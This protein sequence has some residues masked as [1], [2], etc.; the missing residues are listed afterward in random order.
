METAAT[1]N[2]AAGEA[3][4]HVSGGPEP[5]TPDRADLAADGM[6]RDAAQAAARA[7]LEAR[8]AARRRKLEMLSD[9]GVA[10]SRAVGAKALRLLGADAEGNLPPAPAAEE[11]IE[12]A[13]AAWEREAAEARAGTNA[14]PAEATDRA[15][16]RYGLVFARISRMAQI[17][18]EAEARFDRVPAAA[19]R[20]EDATPGAGRAANSNRP[21]G[22]PAE[23]L[24]K[25]RQRLRAALEDAIMDDPDLDQVQRAGKVRKLDEAMAK[26]DTDLELLNRPF[27][28]AVVDICKDLGVASASVLSR[29]SDADM[30]FEDELKAAV[31][32][33]WAV[34][35][36]ECDAAGDAWRLPAGI[37]GSPGVPPAA[38]AIAQARAAAQAAMQAAAQT[39]TQAAAEGAAQEGADAAAP[40][41]SPD[42]S[43][44]APAG[45]G[46]HGTQA[47]GPERSRR[48]GL[49]APPSPTARGDPAVRF[50]ISGGSFFSR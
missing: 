12:A 42:P 14:E 26:T 9:Q 50:G 37:I 1:L 28:L 17:L 2:E 11:S 8:Y 23:R 49:F 30:G 7:A 41:P 48:P 3:E 45:A 35:Q 18:V 38:V 29:L 20:D 19:W 46:T 10:L 24:R 47:P 34:Q 32:A 44:G 25:L 6:D 27:G 40:D 39:A 15:V 4:R 33:Y 31:D 13:A 5:D 16:A 43:P 21:V 22:V 36:A